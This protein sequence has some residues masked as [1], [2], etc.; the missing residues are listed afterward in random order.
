MSIGLF[1][2]IIIIIIIFLEYAKESASEVRLFNQFKINLD[3]E[4]FLK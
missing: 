1:I 2:T 4:H 3:Q